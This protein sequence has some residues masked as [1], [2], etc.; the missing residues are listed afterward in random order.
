MVDSFEFLHQRFAWLNCKPF[1][2][3][4]ALS[5]HRFLE[6]INAV[7]PHSLSSIP[8]LTLWALN[9]REVKWPTAYYFL[10]MSHSSFFAKAALTRFFR[11]FFAREVLDLI[12]RLS[13]LNEKSSTYMSWCSWQPRNPKYCVKTNHVVAIR[14]FRD[15]LLSPALHLQW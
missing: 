11:I 10:G 15:W 14:D 6:G 2:F 12:C 13:L 9:D 5:S 4:L 7:D 8:H 1:T 3:S